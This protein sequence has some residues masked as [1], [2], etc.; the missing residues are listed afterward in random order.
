MQMQPRPTSAPPGSP[1][2]PS[3]VSSGKGGVGKTTVSVNLSVVLAR[4]EGAV[5]LLD[6]DI[7]GPNVPM[8][9]GAPRNSPRPLTAKSFPS[10][11]TAS[12]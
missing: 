8:M 12:S 2:T 11:I 5:G 4:L 9:M 6:A 7:Y 3:P 10:K 1:G